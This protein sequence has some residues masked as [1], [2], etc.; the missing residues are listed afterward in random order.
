VEIKDDKAIPRNTGKL[1]STAEGIALKRMALSGL[2]QQI[3]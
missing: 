3:L 2:S 1:L